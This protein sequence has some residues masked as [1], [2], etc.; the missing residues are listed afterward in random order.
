LTAYHSIN[1][2]RQVGKAGAAPPLLGTL[3]KLAAASQTTGCGD[4][5]PLT[6]AVSINPCAT[7]SDSMLRFAAYSAVALGS[8]NALWWEALLA[9]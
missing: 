4:E 8:A 6:P 5:S 9:I 3:A 1:I 7:D 2:R